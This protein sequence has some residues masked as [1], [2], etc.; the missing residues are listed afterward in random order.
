VIDIEFNPP[1]TQ[2]RKELG[3]LEK[4][5]RDKALHSATVYAA[6]PYKDAMKREAPQDTGILRQAIGHK[7]LSK[8]ARARLGVPEQDSA[9]LIGPN[10]KVRGRA[11]GRVAAMLEAGAKPHIIRPR[12]R[13]GVLSWVRGMAVKSVRHP[14]FRANPFM[15]RAYETAGGDVQRRFYEGLAKHLDRLKS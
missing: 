7:K 8:T 10:R 1:I 13:R 11:R 4:A 6:K 9:L 15:R 14:G 2:L 5:L 12:R 3:E